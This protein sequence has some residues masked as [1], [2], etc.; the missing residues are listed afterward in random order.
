MRRC[1]RVEAHARLPAPS[2]ALALP[3][4][5]RVRELVE[6]RTDRPTFLPSA[7]VDHAWPCLVRILV[8]ALVICTCHGV[9]CD[10][11]TTTRGCRRPVV[12]ARQSS[13]RTAGGFKS[14]VP[15]RRC[16][17]HLCRSW[18]SV[19][20]SSLRPACSSLA[21][22]A[23]QDARPPRATMLAVALDEASRSCAPLC[24]AVRIAR[25]RTPRCS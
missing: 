9:V 20:L 13:P 16:C 17:C 15:A 21:R 4:C 3:S 8:R 25:R 18:G 2:G 11:C 5:C 6:V 24:G 14:P 1:E 12:E 23:A 10:G 22:V 19:G 7:D